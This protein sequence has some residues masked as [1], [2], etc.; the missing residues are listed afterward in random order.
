MKRE[1]LD[2]LAVN[3]FYTKRFAFYVSR[4]CR[5]G[6][7]KD[8]ARELRLDWHTVKELEKQYM[9]EQL[10]RVGQPGPKV[11]DIDEISIRKGHSYRIVVSDLLRMRPIWFGGLDRSEDSMGMFYAELGERSVLKLQ[12]HG[13]STGWSLALLLSS[14]NPNGPQGTSHSFAIPARDNPLEMRSISLRPSRRQSDRS[15]SRGAKSSL[16][17]RVIPRVACQAGPLS[18]QSGTFKNL[19]L[20]S[21][22]QCGTT[23]NHP[24]ILL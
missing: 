14:A 7:I 11:I 3:P 17:V 20:P 16:S 9:R 1:G 15:P 4:R 12:L 24:Q 6:T 13:W 10:R 8:V 2:W 23:E 22:K 18:K 19:T 5:A 21:A